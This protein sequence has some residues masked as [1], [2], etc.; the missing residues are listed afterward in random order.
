VLR[1]EEAARDA[2]Q[3]AFL[4]V[5]ASLSRFEG[6]SSFYTW[7][8]RVVLNL[9]LDV[10]RRDRSARYVEWTEEIAGGAG[11]EADTDESPDGAP[12]SPQSAL[13]R[14]E[15]REHMTAAIEDLPDAAR[16][17]LLLREVDGLS[18]EEIS[19]A[20]EI[21]K[22]TVMSRLHYAR[23]RIQKALIGAGLVG[24]SDAPS[25]KAARSG[26]EPGDEPEDGSDA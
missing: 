16:R 24:E 13:E 20:L 15:L 1:D 11:S 9:C 10:K 21:P 5:Y 17:T 8:Y 19:R 18:Y 3:E 25:G 7:L 14:A 4:K 22:G 26:D 23:K 12:S 6:R 2:V